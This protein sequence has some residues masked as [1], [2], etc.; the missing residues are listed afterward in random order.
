M[1]ESRYGSEPEA[2]AYR[3]IA[4]IQVLAAY[5][6]RIRQQGSTKRVEASSVG[7]SQVILAN[8]TKTPDFTDDLSA[9]ALVLKAWQKDTKDGP[10]SAAHAWESGSVAVRTIYCRP[11]RCERD[12][13]RSDPTIAG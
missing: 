5:C 12:G 1:A 4:K 10:P 6:Q 13:S 7:F 2:L 9:K 3:S 8:R 11:S